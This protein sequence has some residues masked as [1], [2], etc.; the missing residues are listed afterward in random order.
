MPNK[1][2]A[3]MKEA[4][5]EAFDNAGGVEFLVRMSKGSAA[6]R[7]AFANICAKLIPVQLAGEVQAALK[8]I[9]E[10]Q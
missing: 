1:V 7:I 9:H 6:E 5:R 3:S 8:I 4:V 2:T 10:S